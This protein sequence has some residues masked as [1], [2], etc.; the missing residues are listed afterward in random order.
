MPP[1]RPSLDAAVLDEIQNTSGDLSKVARAMG[2]DFNALKTRFGVETALLNNTEKDEPTDIRLLARPKLRRYVIAA[3]NI[4]TA[5]PKKY[6]AIIAQHRRNY[7]AG[8]HEMAQSTSDGW[9]VLY[10]IPRL[11]KTQPRKFFSTLEYATW[12]L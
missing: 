2:L 7:D 8:T 11:V 1:K 6:D 12:G 9:V 5:W 10:S 4:G 3:K